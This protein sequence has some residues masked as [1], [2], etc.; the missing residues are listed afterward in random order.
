[1]DLCC[2]FVLVA[3]IT[4]PSSTKSPVPEVCHSSDVHQTFPY[5]LSE[6]RLTQAGPVWRINPINTERVSVT[7]EDKEISE[8]TS[9]QK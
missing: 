1:M 9:G 2:R 6:A 5:T 8:Q 3:S 7:K 4:P